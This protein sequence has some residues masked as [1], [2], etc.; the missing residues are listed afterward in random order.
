MLSHLGSL[1]VRKFLDDYWQ[2]KPL[3]IS[4]AIKDLPNLSAE[5]LA[6]YA[7]EES[8]ESRL[9]I[10]TRLPQQDPLNSQWQ[11]LNGPFSEQTFASLPDSHWTLLVQAVDQLNESVHRIKSLFSFI[12]NWRIDDIM[13]S[14][15]CDQ[16]NA[17]PHFDYY[18]VFLLQIQGKRRWKIGQPCTSQ[19]PLRNDTPCKLLTEFKTQSEHLCD[20]GDLLYIPPGVAHW[21]IAE[22]ECLT[23]SVG[24]RAPSHEDILQDLA[25]ELSSDWNQDQRYTDQAAN[26][27][28]SNPGLI[29]AK[30]LKPIQD[31]LRHLAADQNALAGWFGN[32]MTQLKRETPVFFSSS[33][34]RYTVSPLARLAY[35][36]SSEGQARL[37]ANGETFQCSQEFAAVLCAGDVSQINTAIDNATHSQDLETLHNLLSY[38][39]LIDAEADLDPQAYD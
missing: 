30:D 29:E 8:V 27:P 39:I 17:G 21:G 19:S 31:L 13:V 12:P 18:D 24:F 10:E 15:A 32:Y 26:L 1:S 5:E 16:G 35:F 11:L 22:G 14:Y 2:R 4:E 37:F 6:G 28:K 20:R 25:H 36:V 3:F 38:G 33:E 7:L 23:L 34:H 9:L